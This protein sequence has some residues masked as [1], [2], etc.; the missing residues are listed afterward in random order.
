MYRV[1]GH[2]GGGGTPLQPSDPPAP[3]TVAGG[4]VPDG[5]AL[6]RAAFAQA[7]REL[8]GPVYRYARH[9]VCSDAEAEDVAAAAFQRALRALDRCPGRG[10]LRPW[11]FGIARNVLREHRRR[12]RAHADLAAVADVLPEPAPEPG[13]AALA[14]EEAAELRRRIA[15]LPDDQ[16]DAL[17][18]RFMAE[19]STAEAAE[20]LGRSAGATKMLV[21]RAITGLRARYAQ[22]ADR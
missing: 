11:L 2:H 10:Q 15:A 12:A 4:P 1:Q 9:L 22:E 20:L 7:Y 14:R 19:L 6:D 5:G 16:R 3:A 21:H 18:L 13:M 8:V 17:L